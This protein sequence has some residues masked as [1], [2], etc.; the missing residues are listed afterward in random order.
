MCLLE[1]GAGRCPGAAADKWEALPLDQWRS[2][3]EPKKKKETSIH[4][5]PPEQ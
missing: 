3:E 4:Q 1:N 2:S 5:V